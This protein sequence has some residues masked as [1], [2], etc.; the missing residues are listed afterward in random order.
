MNESISLNIQAVEHLKTLE[1][2]HLSPFLLLEGRIRGVL[3]N[4]SRLVNQILASHHADP[5][6]GTFLGQAL[7]AGALL[8]S[9]LKNQDRL[10]IKV[11]CSGPLKGLVV[12]TNA[13]GDISGRPFTPQLALKEAPQSLDPDPWLG[14]GFLSIT[15]MNQGAKEPFT[16]TTALISGL[17]SQ[18][19][20]H[21]FLKSEQIPTAFSLGVHWDPQGFAAGAGGLFLQAMPGA[22]EEDL[23][24]LEILLNGLAPLSRSIAGGQKP[25]ALVQQ[26]FGDFDLQIL[27]KKSLRFYCSCSKERFGNFIAGL[28]REELRDMAKNGPF[29]LQTTCKQCNAHYSFTQSELRAML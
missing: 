27:E 22:E 10:Q 25:A 8:S 4:G 26:I 18:N 6:V 7:I 19:L 11:E 29:P 24:D 28:E 14:A 15:R 2:D 3:A 12:E 13:L 5:L 1:E 20:A 17:L 21:Y 23:E 9:S 16:G